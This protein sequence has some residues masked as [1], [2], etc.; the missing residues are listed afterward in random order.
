LG[1][2][3]G[4]RWNARAAGWAV[5][6]AYSMIVRLAKRRRRRSLSQ[7]LA[8]HGHRLLLVGLV[9]T[10]NIGSHQLAVG[11]R[12]WQR[13]RLGVVACLALGVVGCGGTHSTSGPTT[14]T[15]TPPAAPYKINLHARASGVRV[16]RVTGTTNLP[17][18]AVLVLSASRAFRNAYEHDV[19]A[20]NAAGAHVTVS[21]GRFSGVL[22][23]NE[24]LLLLGIAGG[25]VDPTMGPVAKVDS[26]VT[27][28]VDFETGKDNAGKTNQ[29][30]PSVRSAVGEFGERLRNSPQRTVFGSLTPNPENWLEVERRVALKSYLLG[31]IAHVQGREP[32]SARLAGFCL[33]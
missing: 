10:L 1:E 20:V 7:R 6:A 3:V 13:W 15:A 12:E 27:V 30:D 16:I 11:L 9:G 17:D 19:R 28:C 8:D 14:L 26:A 31:T 33:T 2:Q 32:E 23:L 24:R 21:D 4:D 25:K 29:P 5:T 18:R 22:R